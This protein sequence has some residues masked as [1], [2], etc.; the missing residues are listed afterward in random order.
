MFNRKYIF[1]L[2]SVHCH[3]P[4][5]HLTRCDR[6]PRE[7]GGCLLFFL[8]PRT[9]KVENTDGAFRNTNENMFLSWPIIWF[10]VPENPEAR[11][12]L[13][14]ISGGM[15]QCNSL[16]RLPRVAT[17]AMTH[18]NSLKFQPLV[19][20]ETTS[21][22]LSAVSRRSETPGWGW[23]PKGGILQIQNAGTVA[24]CVYR[25]PGPSKDS[26]EACLYQH[27]RKLH[28]QRQRYVQFVGKQET[29]N[30]ERSSAIGLKPW[31]L[32]LT[33]SFRFWEFIWI[34]KL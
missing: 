27:V 3:V 4:N 13:S 29:Q 12:L 23:T 30:V 28:R 25:I 15:I 18:C 19:L 22:L 24:G 2:W 5:H 31:E 8:P 21:I 16:S 34:Y 26:S 33:C 6:I 1:K 7:N 9:P 14:L 32:E 10:I 17:F 11:P 20:T